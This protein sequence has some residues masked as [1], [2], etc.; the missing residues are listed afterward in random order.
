MYVYTVCTYTCVRS[1]STVYIFMFTGIQVDYK[2]ILDL[3]ELQE[4]E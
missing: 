3:G 2:F 4:E 1:V